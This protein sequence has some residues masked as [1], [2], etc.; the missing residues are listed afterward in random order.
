MTNIGVIGSGFVGDAI[1]FGFMNKG[2]NVIM[3]DINKERLAQ[4]RRDGFVTEEDLEVVV[5]TCDYLFVQV[6]TLSTKDGIDLSCVNKV[7]EDL[8]P[9]LAKNPGTKYIIIKSTV[10]PGTTEKIAKDLF[11]AAG[12][13]FCP[14]FLQEK[15]ARWDFLNPDRI[16]IGGPRE[17]TEKVAELFSR[18]KAPIIHTSWGAAEMAKYAHNLWY[19]TNISYWNDIV[20]LCHF[21]SINE[22]EVH[23]CVMPG[24]WFGE[25]PWKIGKPFAGSCI[26]KDLRAVLSFAKEKNIVLP[27]LEAVEKT[28][29]EVGGKKYE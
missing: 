26:P 3:H 6:P 2:F 25:H 24:R 19:A 18:F 8:K 5:M 10:L 11:D 12:V 14:E 23:K 17:V 27:V 28:N 16:I 22:K 4:L 20:R 21:C 13:V 1:G 9:L 15:N 7:V 29:V